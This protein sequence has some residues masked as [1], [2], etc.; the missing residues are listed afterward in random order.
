MMATREKAKKPN[1][2][3]AAARARSR[4]SR[5]K[6]PVAASVSATSI[7][8][9]VLETW[10]VH[11][12]V[13]EILLDGIP[14]KGLQARPYGS[15]G[16]TVSEQFAHM[17]RVRLGW[18]FYQEKGARPTAEELPPEKSLG[19]ARIRSELRRSARAVEAFLAAHLAA[20]Q[21]IREFRG[22]PVRWMGYLIAHESHHRGLILLALKQEKVPISEKVTY[23]LWM[24]W[25]SGT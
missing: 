7:T 12:V 1:S 17:I 25:M 10:R 4:A 24:R 8:E 3:R 2:P 23:Q 15:R 14:T 11:A 20:G 18:L 21:E 13:N 5:A 16:R 22:N 19:K 9:Q 6:R